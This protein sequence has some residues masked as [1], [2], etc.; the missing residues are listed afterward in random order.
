MVQQ[1][2]TTDPSNIHI[3]NT[4]HAQP[5]IRGRDV[6][7]QRS[8][9]RA[10]SHTNKRAHLRRGPSAA[11]KREEARLPLRR[12]FQKLKATCAPLV[13]REHVVHVLLPA[14]GRLSEGWKRGIQKR[15]HVMH[16]RKGKWRKQGKKRREK[17]TSGVVSDV[18]EDK[19]RDEEDSAR[20]PET[21]QA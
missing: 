20:W 14:R 4:K 8:A 7:P 12:V 9:G 13:V 15:K 10:A 2:G 11:C 5:T 1:N 16:E 19:E 18:E 6:R 21:R 17:R 3:A